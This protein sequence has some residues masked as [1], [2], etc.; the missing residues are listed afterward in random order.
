MDQIRPAEK[1]WTSDPEGAVK[2]RFGEEAASRTP[3]SIPTVFNRVVAEYPNTPALC[4][5]NGNN[6]WE[7]LTFRQYKEK[8]QHFA[9][10][11]IKLGLKPRYSV[12]IIA[13]NCP[14]YLIGALAIMHAG[15]ILS[16]IYTTSSPE[17]ILDVLNDSRSN[18]VI[19]G[20][21]EQLEKVLAVRKKAKHL[22]SIVQ[23]FPSKIAN[24]KS[25]VEGY[26]T[27]NELELTALTQYQTQLDERL[28]NICVNECCTIVF[29]SGTTGK[30]KG[31]MLSHDNITWTAYATVQRLADVCPG[32]ESYVSYLPLCHMAGQ[33]FDIYLPLMIGMT[34]YFAE[35]DAIKGNL[36][37]TLK[38]TKPNRI[39][40]VPK[41]LEKMYEYAEQDKC[42]LGSTFFKESL[43]LSNMKSIL[44]GAAPLSLKV[45]RYFLNKNITILEAYGLTET[46]GPH[47]LSSLKRFNEKSVGIPLDGCEVKLGAIDVNKEGHEEL[48]V[49][50][51]NIFMGYIGM[52]DANK[53]S[54]YG[55]GWLHTGDVGYI[56]DE[57][58]IYVTDRIKELIIT[59]GG[60]KV[61]PSHIEHQIKAELPIISNICLVGDK[62]R[63]VSALV[64][65]KTEVNSETG[66]PLDGLKP[67]VRAWLKNLGLE[68]TKL[69]EVIAAGPDPI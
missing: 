37:Q 46:C 24:Y 4:C 69:S 51:R 60:S 33:M 42:T 21:D 52:E 32:K 16:G 9:K 34:V 36:I 28:R 14:Q 62:Q 49:R 17:A 29:T 38:C 41:I 15:G 3:T 10:A 26:Y 44:C 19:V 50:G 48:L 18:I 25:K 7:T 63:Y 27:W 8:V 66:E 2:L 35:K 12:S 64:T 47:S 6:T 31:V 23:I 45:K 59:S 1:F 20:E 5:K 39:F 43:G 54:F 30:S 22:K 67:E 61:A 65:L 40:V 58:F 56:D 11:L 53:K 13:H 68:Y 57:G 55:E